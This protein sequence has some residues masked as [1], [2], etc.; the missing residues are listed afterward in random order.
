MKIGINL[1]SVSDPA[2]IKKWLKRFCDAGYDVVEFN[3]DILPFIIG[4]KLNK[5]MTGYM[6]NLLS[7]F[8]LTYTM[9][10]GYGVDLRDQ[11]NYELNEKALLSSVEAA[12][13]TGAI[14]LNLHYEKKSNSKKIENKFLEGHL[15]ACDKAEKLGLN[16]TIENIEVETVDPVIEFVKTVNRKNFK[17]NYDIGHGF[18][19]ANYFGFDFL[20]SVKKA[21]PH[22]GHLHFSDNTG[23]FEMLRLTNKPLY[24]NLP[25]GTRFAFGRGDI[26]LPPLWGNIPYNKVADILKGYDK[27]II[28]E[29][30][31]GYFIPF[32]KEIREN[33]E[34]L[35]C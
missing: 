34:K 25:M 31:S 29:F 27:T 21:E 33:T 28:C 16:L 20:E 10:I 24:D 30:Y 7:D 3:A 1:P 26:H 5:E 22:L 32:L 13:E 18:L 35:F 2:D 9:H 8:P 14:L 12:S 6:K 15:N 23:K 11:E 17:M 19:A 4:G